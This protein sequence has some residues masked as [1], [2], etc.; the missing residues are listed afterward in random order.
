M[1]NKILTAVAGAFIATSAAATTGT[2]DSSATTPNLPNLCEFTNVVD[3]VMTWNETTGVFDQTSA[4][5]VSMKVRDVISVVVNTDR[6]LYDQTNATMANMLDEVDYSASTAASSD[7]LRSLTADG[8]PANFT[9]MNFDA[10][11]YFDMLINHTA[12]PSEYFVAADFT[13]Y[14]VTHTITCNF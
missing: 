4:P 9:V 6:A 14:Y 11:Q 5:S 13:T 3:G 10:P 2:V 1:K 12:V 8:N 7:A